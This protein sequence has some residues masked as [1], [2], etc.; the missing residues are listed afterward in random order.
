MGDCGSGGVSQYTCKG[1]VDASRDLGLLN[2]LVSGF[3]CTQE[4]LR[5]RSAVFICLFVC[6]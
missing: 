3:R 5:P 4:L 2:L 1:S 6:F